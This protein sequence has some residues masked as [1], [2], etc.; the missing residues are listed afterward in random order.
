[1]PSTSSVAL[2]PPAAAVRRVL[3]AP[4]DAVVIAAPPP[5]AAM[6]VPGRAGAFLELTKPR[7]TRLVTL[8]SA[9]GFLL[10]PLAPGWSAAALA[11]VAA[12]ALVGTALSAA[13]ANTLNQHA[14]RRRDALM[15]R[16]AGR[17]L[18]TGRVAPTEAL[19]LGIALCAAGLVTLWICCGPAPAL[20]SL[21]TILS[22][23][24]CY[25]PLKPITPWAA[26]VGA[27]PGALPPLIGWCAAA[28][29]P[30]RTAGLDPLPFAGLADAGGW[31]LVALMVVWQLPH[32][33]ALSWMYRDDY[34]RGGHRVLP[35]IEAE[36]RLTSYCVA[37]TSLLL[38]PA[39]LLPAWA[40]PDRLGP[41]YITVAA[42][43]GVAFAAVAL[44][45]TAVRTRDAA[46]A[47]FF[48]S[49]IHLPLLLLAMLAEVVVRALR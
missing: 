30:A 27:V 40:I 47:V 32:V 33:L 15:P 11:T 17:P 21:A 19:S 7:I 20:V 41:A 18:P 5:P 26:L 46:R 16:T 14:E 12:G 2:D 22:Y 48:G 37:L 3:P 24:F 13:G 6:A 38:I 44:R 23:V 4:A 35:A 43:S 9:G 29:V 8:T 10:A 28:A 42:L 1:M 31:S 36:P 34:A 45:L 49:I 25:T 39:T